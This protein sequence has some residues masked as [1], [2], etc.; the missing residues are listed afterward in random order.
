MKHYFTKLEMGLWAGSVLAILAAL[1][2]GAKW[3]NGKQHHFLLDSH[4]A[5]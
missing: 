4:L 1:S 5:S 2:A 3:K